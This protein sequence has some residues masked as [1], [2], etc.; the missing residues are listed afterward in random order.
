MSLFVLPYL[1]IKRIFCSYLLGAIQNYKRSMVFRRIFQKKNRYTK[2]HSLFTFSL[3][4]LYQFFLLNTK[5]TAAFLRYLYIQFLKKIT[6]FKETLLAFQPKRV[7]GIWVKMFFI[8]IALF[9]TYRYFNGTSSEREPYIANNIVILSTLNITILIVFVLALIVG[10]NIF[11]ILLEKKNSVFGSKLRIKLVYSLVGLTLIP[12]IILFVTS[13]GLINKV[14]EG[15]FNEQFEQSRNASLNIARRHYGLLKNH[16]TN[17][18]SAVRKQIKEYP[19]ESLIFPLAQTKD[20]FLQKLEL[21][22]KNN[23]LFSIRIFSADRALLYEVNHPTHILE[24]FQEPSVSSD[25]IEKS[26]FNQEYPLYEEKEDTLFIRTYITVKKGK[27]IYPITVSLRIDPDLAD[28]FKLVNESFRNNE[29]LRLFK[30]PIKSSYVLT[31][32][33]LTLM[34]L[35]GAVWIALYL[36]RQI[37]T[38]IE[39]LALG[40]LQVSKGNYNIQIEGADEQ[41]ELGHL[42]KQ[43]NQM[44]TELKRSRTELEER[45]KFTELILAYVN[46]AVISIDRQRLVRLVNKA[47][48]KLF[49]LEPLNLSNELTLSQLLGEKESILIIELLCTLEENKENSTKSDHVNFVDAEIGFSSKHGEL[50]LITTIGKIFDAEGVWTSSIVTFD[51]ITEL[52]KAQQ[53]VAWREVAQRIAHE[54]KNPLTPIQLSAQRLEKIRV[55]KLFPNENEKNILDEIPVL[56]STNTEVNAKFKEC[57]QAILENV[58]SIKKLADE[59]S[60]FARMPAAEFKETNL[61]NLLSEVLLNYT[62]TGSKVTL[63]FIPESTLPNLI[64]D[65]EQIRRVIINLLDNALDAFQEAEHEL[66]EVDQPKILIRTGF[67]PKKDSVYIEIS[68]NGPGIAKKNRSKIFDPYFTTKEKGTGLGL[69]IVSTIITEHKGSIRVVENEP[70]GTKFIIEFKIGGEQGKN[71]RRISS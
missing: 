30:K 69:S 47:A 61:N 44:V 23:S 52:S 15:W 13:S 51:D 7:S 6:F 26:L 2:K 20:R 25:L 27:S 16:L 71:V 70:K 9:F 49:R 66:S 45:R 22:R 65:S 53:L 28:S 3:F 68:D 24:S 59:F 38:P 67:T 39:K 31:L 64:L 5:N 10:R 1:C 50:K 32:F 41:D 12:T 40:T 54:I 4:T 34:I 36:A 57:T 48:E 60:K 29:K 43:F 11:K 19:S 33:I 35:F 14:I 62:E 8:L 63:Q 17:A 42:T 56:T 58:S 55:E 37:V 18:T 21:I 46:I